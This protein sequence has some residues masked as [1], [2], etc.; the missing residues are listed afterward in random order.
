MNAHTPPQ[1]TAAAAG[2]SQW[3]VRPM[4]AAD[5]AAMRALFET[6]FGAPLSA[7]HWA[8]KYAQGR[9][10]GIGVW[11]RQG[12]MVA[13]YGGAVRDILDAGVSHQAVQG[14]D[15]CVLPEAR[16]R[17]VRKGAYYHAATAFYSCYVGQAAPYAYFF[18]FPSRRHFDLG[19]RLGLNAE[20]DRISEFSF[21]PR[22]GAARCDV[23]AQP[24]AQALAQPRLRQG[25]ADAWRRQQSDLAAAIVG[26][27]DAR[28]I[29]HR[30]AQHPT[31][32]YVLLAVS[33]WTWLGR[34]ARAFAVVRQ[35]PDGSLLW[36]D[37]I[38][39]LD[40]LAQMAACVQRHARRHGLARVHGWITASQQQHFAAAGAQL[41]PTEVVVPANTWAGYADF[42]AQ[43]G[44][45]WLMA[46]DTDFL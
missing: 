5:S 10:V 22:P 42:S 27:R 17:L 2:V 20:L 33:R 45:W 6:V 40:D 13:H 28:F 46:G 15:V 9:G 14:A 19:R 25:L 24:V 36:L 32:N 3:L 39:A 11:D 16:G 37:Y 29:D 23:P 31:Q 38:G 8:W 4:Q 26:Q 7:E 41:T 18:G 12:R 43:L 44:R 35:L 30:Y 34:R 1:D 21:L